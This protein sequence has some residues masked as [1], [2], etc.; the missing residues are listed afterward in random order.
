MIINCLHDGTAEWN[1]HVV[2]DNLVRTKLALLDSN[3]KAEV[4][5]IKIYYI[6][7]T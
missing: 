2:V 5:P 6:V 3:V 4:H 7:A 1:T